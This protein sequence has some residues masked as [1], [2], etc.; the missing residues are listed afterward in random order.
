MQID[1][2]LLLSIILT[3]LIK[4]LNIKPESSKLIEVK[5]WKSFEYSGTENHFRKGTLIR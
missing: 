3:K 5:L 4:E 2:Y 1:P